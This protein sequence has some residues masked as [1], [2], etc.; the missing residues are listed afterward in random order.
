MDIP[1]LTN[2]VQLIFTLF[3]QFEQERAREKPPKRGHPLTYTEKTFLVFF[4]LMQFRR[5][6]AFKPQ[7]RWLKTHLDVLCLLGW[8]SVPHRKTI[9]TCSKALY[10]MLQN[11]M[12]F[13][14][15]HAAWL[16]EA[17]SLKH[18]VA[19]KSLF[20]AQGPVWYQSDREANSIP[21][22][23]RHVDVHATWSKSGYH[24]W[25]YG[26]GLHSLRNKAAFLAFVQVE[27]ACVAESAVIHPQVELIL[28][29]LHPDT[30]AVDNSYA[31]ASRIRRWTKRGVILLSPAYRWVKGRYAQAYHRFLKQPDCQ[32][33]LSQRKTSVEPFFDLVAKMLGADGPQKQLLVQR[34][35]NVR[36]YLALA[37]F[38]V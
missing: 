5:I 21:A 25:V 2:Y 8:T 13:V 7:W 38:S 18:L 32:Q 23:L 19:D 22:K 4:R 28:T 11:F 1:T 15:Q 6:Y 20:K 27:T 9:S 14:A 34:F 37:V 17:F 33:Y 12:L 24:G 30:L 3:E 26:Y 29:D 35:K 10:P 16:D 31:K 36:A